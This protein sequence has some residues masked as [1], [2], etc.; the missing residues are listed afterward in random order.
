MWRD[1]Y[2]AGSALKITPDISMASFPEGSYVVA[3][4]G[5]I[6]SDLAGNYNMGG[7]NIM[8]TV[9]QNA[10]CPHLGVTGFSAAE[11]N[12]NGVY[13][14]VDPLNGHAA[15]TRTENQILHLYWRERDLTQ[16]RPG[17]WV[18][19]SQRGGSGFLAYAN[20]SMM[21]NL[22]QEGQLRPP[23]QAWKK[24]ESHRWLEHSDIMITCSSVVDRKSPILV[25]VSFTHF[26]GLTAGSPNF[27]H[28]YFAL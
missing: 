20:L 16:G 9:S 17:S 26:T 14:A 3:Y 13:T 21:E 24:F 8:F 25:K 15:W 19:S 5:G 6:I 4:E 2:C 1:V 10:G 23:G 7:I 18:I 22:G 27:S 11:N 28:N 12:P